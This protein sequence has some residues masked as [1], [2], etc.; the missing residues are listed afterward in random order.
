M[1]IKHLIQP[2]VDWIH[3]KLHEHDEDGMIKPVFKEGSYDQAFA[4]ANKAIREKNVQA[5]SIIKTHGRV[6][7]VKHLIEKEECPCCGETYTRF[8]DR[9]RSENVRDS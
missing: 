1:I 6:S 2:V 4:A 3:H 8:C 5:I 7:A 9:E